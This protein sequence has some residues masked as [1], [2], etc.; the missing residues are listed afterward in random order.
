[1]CV[2]FLNSGSTHS[3]RCL[4]DQVNRNTRKHRAYINA[5]PLKNEEKEFATCELLTN[6]CYEK[7]RQCR[8]L[9][10]CDG[11]YGNGHSRDSVQVDALLQRVNRGTSLARLK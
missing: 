9:R 10:A 4:R 3:H 2:S 8:C 6:L 5:K 11:L 1:M 7:N